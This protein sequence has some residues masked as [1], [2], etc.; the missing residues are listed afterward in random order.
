MKG[1]YLLRPIQVG[2][3]VPTRVGGV[4][5]LGRSSKSVAVVGRVEHDLCDKIRS[6]WPEYQM[7]WYEPAMGARECYI[8]HCQAYHRHENNGLEAKEH[9]AAPGGVDIKC[10]VCGV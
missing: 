1:P 9:P 6:F 4:Y 8:R 3:S 2:M 10:P 5:C 7:F